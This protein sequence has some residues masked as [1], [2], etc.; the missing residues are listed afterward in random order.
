MRAPSRTVLSRPAGPARWTTAQVVVPACLFVACWLACVN[1]NAN[2]RIAAL[3]G[4]LPATLEPSTNASGDPRVAK[5]RVWADAAVRAQPKWRE[6][7]VE[8]IDAASQFWIPM[9][10]IRLEL[11]AV[12]EWQR[13]AEPDL[14]LGEL[15]TLD[16]GGDVT[17]VLGFTAAAGKESIALSQLGTANLFGKHVLIRDWSAR[18]ETDKL[19]SQLKP[20]TAE[21]RVEVVSAHRR[22][23]QTVVLLHYLHV[24]AGAIAEEDEAWIGSRGYSPSQRTISDRSR[25]LLEISLKSRLAEEPE[26][27]AAARLID[28]IERAEF[29]GWVATDRDA[30]VG[31]LRGLVERSKAGKVAG[32]VPPEAEAQYQLSRRL[33]ASDPEAALRELEPLLAAYPV[34][35]A[36]HQLRCDALLVKPGVGDDKTRSACDRVSELAPG[37]PRPHLAVARAWSVAGD[38]S[39]ARAALLLAAGKAQAMQDSAQ[40]FANILDQYRAMGALTWTEEVVAMMPV[41]PGKSSSAG[42]WA[43]GIRARYGVPRGARFVTPAD[44]G[45]LVAAIRASLDAVYAEKSAL[46]ETLVAQATKR[47]PKAPGLAAVRCD[48]A[49]RREQIAAARQQCAIALR[50]DDGQ[51]WA[52]YLSGILALRIPDNAGGVAHLRKAIAL[53]PDLGQ[54]WR[55]LA[56][57][58]QRVGDKAALQQLGADYQVRFGQPLP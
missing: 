14:A 20:L 39:K 53:D 6:L 1:P 34:N 23:K 51:S 50:G 7:I 40:A 55:A 54:A 25:Q 43:A 17:W 49:L 52:H 32:D 37:D 58:L 16:P 4:A 12:R 9:F 36:L 35:A 2:A 10:G 42:Q 41:E 11:T 31:Q 18:S 13:S 24:T 19:E 5:V 8:Q 38:R 26:G 28:E 46:A 22:H 30:I 44:E 45:D 47:W 21:E 27:V 48:L 3:A 33:A 56:Q 57:A 29:A 15:A